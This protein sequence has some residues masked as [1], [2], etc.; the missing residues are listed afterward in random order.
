MKDPFKD[1]QDY[2]ENADKH[3]QRGAEI[4]G[5]TEIVGVLIDTTKNLNQTVESRYGELNKLI[6][7]ISLT[8]GPRGVQGIDGEKGKDGRDGTNGEDGYSPVKG[9]D[10]VDGKNGEKGDMPPVAEFAKDVA[11]VAL[12]SGKSAKDSMKNIIEKWSFNILLP[13]GGT[14][15]R[16]TL[17]GTEA[18]TGTDLPMVSNSKVVANFK[19]QKA[20]DFDQLKA[21]LFNP[22]ATKAA[23]DYFDRVAQKDSLASKFDISG[24]VTSKENIAKLKL[25]SD[26]ELNLYIADYATSTQKTILTKLGKKATDPNSLESIF[27]APAGGKPSLDSIFK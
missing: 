18:V 6:N 9:I 21:L 25:M 11:N 27:G 2:L 12:G 17:Q 26:A 8:P 19:L 10:Y 7:N 14:Q 16:K 22:Y 13:Y 5:L 15:L 3:L 24:T 4:D 20:S 1:L 23:R